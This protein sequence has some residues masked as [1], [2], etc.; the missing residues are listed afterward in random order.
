VAPR[1]ALLACLK[2]KHNV[3][4]CEAL[5]KAYTHCAEDVE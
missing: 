2:E 1:S 3:L 4:A 5:A